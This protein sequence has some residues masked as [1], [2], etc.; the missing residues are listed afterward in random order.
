MQ[1]SA[2]IRWF[3]KGVL[4]PELLVWFQRAERHSCAG[5]G[6][7]VR[8]DAYLRDA[9]QS[10]LGL[11]LRGGKKGVEIKGLVAVIADGCQASP[12]I[13]PSKSGASGHQRSCHSRAC[14]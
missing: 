12:F 9:R 13:G 1:V 14:R 3:W 10:E 8:T 4:P 2:E 6:G 11:K 7:S 5:G